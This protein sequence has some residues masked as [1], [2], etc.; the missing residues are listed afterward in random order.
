MGRGLES[1]Q[2]AYEDLSGT[3]RRAF[4]RKLAE[5]DDLRTRRG[6]DEGTTDP[7]LTVVRARRA[8]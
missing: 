6:L 5:V 3:R 4:E 1:T 8:G 2:R 7:E